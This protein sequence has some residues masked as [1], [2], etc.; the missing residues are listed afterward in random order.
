M[1]SQWLEH[2]IQARNVDCYTCFLQHS[3]SPS[4]WS[5]IV[6]GLG[7]ILANSPKGQES[8]DMFVGV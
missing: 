4:L 7:F 6:L 2:S 3:I 5:E 8:S 1:T